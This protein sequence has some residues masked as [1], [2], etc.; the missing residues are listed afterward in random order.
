LTSSHFIDGPTDHLSARSVPPVQDHD[1]SIAIGVISV[2]ACRT[3]KRRLALAASAVDCPA[4]R[5]SLRSVGRIDLGD[6]R[7]FVGEHRL[8]LMPADIEDGSVET[9]LLSNALEVSPSGHVLG[10]QALDDDVAVSGCDVSRRFVRPVFASAGLSGFQS[11]DTTSGF[12]MSPGAPFLPRECLAGTTITPLDCLDVI[13]QRVAGSV[14]QH[15]RNGN[16]AID[17][18]DLAIVDR[19]SVNLAAETDLPAKRHKDDCGLGDRALQI[20]VASELDPSDLRQ[21]NSRP[22]LVDLLDMDFAP[23]M[24]ERFVLAFNFPFR[25]PALAREETAKGRIKIF[26]R[27]LLSRLANRPHPIELSAKSGKLSALCHVIQ[28]V[29]RARLVVPPV[30]NALLKRCIPNSTTC[31][32]DLKHLLRLLIGRIKAIAVTMENHIKLYSLISSWL[33]EFNPN[34]RRGFLCRV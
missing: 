3:D 26:Q 2:P 30:I 31:R 34:R 14:T 5:A 25:E 4:G 6:G 27:S 7:A 33:Q 8:D 18:D 28:I 15:Q 11:G 9:A 21:A 17:A 24:T 19:F 1:R 20:A 22:S 12:V 29:A 23:D 16:A 13:W 10:A 32:R